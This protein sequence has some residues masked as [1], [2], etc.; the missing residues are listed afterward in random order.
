MYIL[1]VNRCPLK[2][3]FDNMHD[4]FSLFLT[5]VSDTFHGYTSVGTDNS[6]TAHHKSVPYHRTLLPALTHSCGWNQP[7]D[8]GLWTS[9]YL[10]TRML[11]G[12]PSGEGSQAIVM[13]DHLSP[14][15]VIISWPRWTQPWRV[16]VNVDRLICLMGDFNYHHRSLSNVNKGRW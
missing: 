8:V 4:L 14:D 10:G 1:F 2:K 11:Q 15:P 3:R 9:P 6:V 13:S 7:S 5:N 16:G 12:R